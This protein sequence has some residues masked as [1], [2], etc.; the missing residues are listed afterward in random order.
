MPLDK[1]LGGSS[2]HKLMS[3]RQ[4]DLGGGK[5]R[6]DLDYVGEVGGEQPGKHYGTYTL[7]VEN[8]NVASPIPYTYIGATLLTS[9]GSL[10]NTGSGFAQGTGV[11]HKMRVRGVMR[12]EPTT[13]L[14]L[15]ALSNL[16]MAIE[17]EI[18]P[19]TDTVKGEGWEWK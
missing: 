15:A 11:G 14:K 10:G 8:G 19:A 3:T 5:V 2:V 17:A 7:V 4:T 13:D 1:S 9:G 12:Y 18:D 16:I 6:V